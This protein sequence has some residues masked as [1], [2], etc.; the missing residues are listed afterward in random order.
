[1]L[2]LNG[3]EDVLGENCPPSLVGHSMPLVCH[4]CGNLLR[5]GWL[6]LPL[7]LLAPRC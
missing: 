4:Y 3:K 2:P 6:E 1:M 7:C 5:A